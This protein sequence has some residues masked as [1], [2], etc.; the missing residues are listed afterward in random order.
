MRKPANWRKLRTCGYVVL[1]VVLSTSTARAQPNVA[2]AGE[3]AVPAPAVVAPAPQPNRPSVASGLLQRAW[4]F[5]IARFDDRPITVGTLALGVILLVL[6]IWL[7]RLFS[8]MLGRRILPRVGVH[9]DTAVTY[10]RVFFYVLLL[11]FTLLALNIVNVPLT[12]FTVLGGAI[13]IGVGFGAQAIINNFISGWILLA[14]RQVN[15]NDLIEIDGTV[16]FVRSIGARCTHVRRSDGIDLLI[17]NSLMLERTVVNWTL[18]DADI[19]TK[20]RVGVAYGAPLDKVMQIIQVALREHDRVLRQPG[21]QII[22]EE[23]GGSAL[24]LD[25]YFWVHTNAEMELRIVRSDLRFMLER[26]LR[27]EGIAIAFPQDDVHLEMTRMLEVRM[28]PPDAPEAAA[29]EAADATPTCSSALLHRVGPLASLHEGELHTLAQAAQRRELAA[30][31]IIVEQGASGASL[32]VIAA[33]MLRV[34]VSA[35]TGPAAI[36]RLLP[37]EFFGEMSLLTGAP[38]SATVTAVTQSVVFEIDQA[39]IAPVLQR[40]PEVVRKLSEAVAA[41]KLATDEHFRRAADTPG[42]PQ[43]NLVAEIRERICT[44]FGITNARDV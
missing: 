22:F 40:R 7:S 3:S 21:P 41:R 9:T 32:F 29:G 4:E 33:G 8:A 11:I 18:T 15:I 44:L 1:G 31:E 27:A 12:V 17:P 42:P 2:T 39:M 36:A 6:G 26:M 25:V 16:G 13:A 38:R 35:P 19:R 34:T 30:G 37:G 10:Q 43:R 14:E 5:E 23:F 28:L 20:V 24:V